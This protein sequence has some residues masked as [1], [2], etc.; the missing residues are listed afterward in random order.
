[1][2]QTGGQDLDLISHQL[3]IEDGL[4]LQGGKSEYGKD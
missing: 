2:L 3:G 1:L 4:S